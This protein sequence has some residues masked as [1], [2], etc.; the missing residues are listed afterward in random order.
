M[1]ALTT[2]ALLAFA[3]AQ[4]PAAADAKGPAHAISIHADLESAAASR[5]MV[6]L[7]SFVERH[8]GIASIE[9]HVAPPKGELRAVDRAV[10]AAQAQNA[11]LAMAELIL[12]NPGRRTTDDLVA[13]ARQLRL[14][15][16]S[17][18]TALAR[19]D[20]DGSVA[21]DLAAAAAA[22]PAKPVTVAIDGQTLT[23]MP[24]L[25]DLESRLAVR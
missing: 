8:P 9:F 20:V 12:A 14:D 18:R 19:T 11:G 21:A 10:I 7:R 5:A 15:E 3:T 16:P 4:A 2:L 22:K 17:F 23:A 6:V 24:T 1:I 13:M 25:A